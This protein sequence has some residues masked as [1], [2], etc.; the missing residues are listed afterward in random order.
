MY[1]CMPDHIQIACDQKMQLDL[2]R[3]AKKYVGCR[4]IGRPI[5]FL[6][7]I[8]LTKFAQ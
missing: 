6:C 1:S 2:A 5:G 7:K 8:E 4:P 3:T